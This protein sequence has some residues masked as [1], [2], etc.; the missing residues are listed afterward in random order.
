[1]SASMLIIKPDMPFLRLF[2]GQLK[3]EIQSKLNKNINL[4]EILKDDE[5][6]N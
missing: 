6:T 5:D 1:M 2:R 3:G 4:D